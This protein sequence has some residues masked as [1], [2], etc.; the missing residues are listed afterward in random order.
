MDNNDI[1]SQLNH[2]YPKG[3]PFNMKNIL[4][5]LLH[6]NPIFKGIVQYM[7]GV[8]MVFSRMTVVYQKIFFMGNVYG[9]EGAGSLYFPILYSAKLP[10]GLLVFNLIA[11]LLAV[12]KFIFSKK[13]LSQRTKKFLSNPVSFLIAVFVFCYFAATLSS[14]L[15]IGLRHIMP[16]ILGLTILTA[17]IIVSFWNNK[18]FRVKL[19]YIFSLILLLI[20]FSVLKAFPNYLSYYNYFAGGKDDGYKIATDS[21]F[22]WGQDAKKLIKWVDEN[23]IKKIYVDIEGNIPL[24]FYIGDAYEVLDLEKY[25]YP[26]PGSYV[27]IAISKYEI[28]N[29]NFTMEKLIKRIGDTIL[30]FKL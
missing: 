12:W 30:V 13:A 25:S 22:D 15:Q 3:L 6:V 14:N 17:K 5:T 26:Q 20:F 11:I 2:Y 8:L 1:V 18:I 24:Q 10:I 21:N 9:A 27:A 4:I 23:N 16:V 19:G 7:S 29:Y 28:K